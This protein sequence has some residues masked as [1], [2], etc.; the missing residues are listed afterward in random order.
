ML[1]AIDV[2]YRKNEARVVGVFFNL[3]DKEPNEVEIV[4]VK[5][6]TEYIPG[7]FYKRE[8]PCLIK[9]IEKIDL[10]NIEAIIID[11]HIYVDNYET[12]GLGGKLYEYLNKKFPIIGVAKNSFHSNSLTVKEIFRGSSKKPLY[13]SAIGIDIDEAVKNIKNMHGDYRIPDILKKLDSITKD[14]F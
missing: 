4:N 6:V 3:I 7:E 9:L 14:H 10:S 12:F 11:G 1:L 5:D 2:Y 13:V 8:L